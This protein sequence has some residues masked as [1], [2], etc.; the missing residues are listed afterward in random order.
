MSI[1]L[2]SLVSSSQLTLGTAVSLSGTAVGFTGIPAGV[3][4]IQMILQG[5]SVT[6]TDDL[7]IQLGS[8]SYT[9]TG[10]NSYTIALQNTSPTVSGVTST[11][12]FNIPSG[13]ATSSIYGIAKFV[14]ITGNIWVGSI[15]VGGIYT[16]QFSF[17]V[18]GS[19]SL[20]GVLDRIRITVS[21]SNT[22]DAG[23][24]NISY[25]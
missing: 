6:G 21:G 7:I 20:S 2:S 13:S 4:E 1:S 17:L 14:N 24:V 18:N 25:Q 5:A 19:I 9:T 16:T 15:S 11:T 3:K 12:G 23:A 8:G 22:F 10:Y